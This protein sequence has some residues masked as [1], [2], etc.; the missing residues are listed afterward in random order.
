MAV[1]VVVDVPGPGRLARGGAGLARAAGIV[2]GGL[3]VLIGL[4]PLVVL[5]LLIVVGLPV[6][7]GEALLGHQVPPASGGED[8]AG[9]WL[10]VSAVA[11]LMVVSLTVG[12]RLLRGRRRLVLFLR[13]FG[14][15]AAT[16]VVTVA[17]ASLGGRWRLVTLDDAS[18][19]PVGVGAMTDV[20]SAFRRMSAG[21]R[22][23]F[24]A[25]GRV[26]A[27]VLV[28][29]FVG[30]VADFGWASRSGID[31]SSVSGRD[32][33]AGVVLRILATVA[34]VAG[35]LL[36]AGFGLQ[37][38]KVVVFPVVA[39]GSTVARAVRD[40]EGAKALEVPNPR[41]IVAAR[42]RARRLSRKVFSP[43]LMVLRVD[44]AI[45]QETVDGVGYVA[46]V[47]LID[48]SD[49][50]ENVNWEIERMTSRF[51]PRCVFIGEH[52]RL[53]YLTT[54]IPADPAAHRVRQLLDGYTVLAYTSDDV[55]SR[56]FVW[57][58]QAALDHSVWM[59]LPGPRMPDPL[60]RQ[61][62]ID[63]RREVMREHRQARR[64]QRAA[65]SLSRSGQIR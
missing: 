29:T 60:P 63:A 17:T 3:L 49:P 64:A 8:L 59:P 10:A 45:W 44:S 13:R 40:A 56:R 62:I 52:S 5:F 7:M 47:P 4:S 57:A 16:H 39:V 18:V 36:V 9:V 53:G 2:V 28:L 25:T 22:R 34:A 31:P 55:G 21:F 46:H 51:G 61:L 33:T 35:S 27:V 24:A 1:T 6:A 11:L 14:H 41:K 65:A 42:D 12:I 38:L 15:T 32:T 50:S 23:A 58:L 19:A 54:P 26:L 43:R 30:C 37:L 20:V 48:V